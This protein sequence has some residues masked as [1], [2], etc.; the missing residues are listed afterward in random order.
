MIQQLITDVSYQVAVQGQS[1]FQ[2]VKGTVLEL[3]ECDAQTLQHSQEQVH[4]PL[5]KKI[6]S[7]ARSMV[8]ERKYRFI[9]QLEQA[10]DLQALY[11][12]IIEASKTAHPTTPEGTYLTAC[13]SAAQKKLL[14][15]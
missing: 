13:L 5:A 15:N 8:F 1:L 6:L 4:S 12:Q 14:R 3:S 9:S 2:A 7:T 10:E 11:V